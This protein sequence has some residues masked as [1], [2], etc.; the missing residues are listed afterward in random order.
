MKVKYKV[1]IIILTIINLISIFNF[2]KVIF[3]GNKNIEFCVAC[4]F[5][6]ENIHEA[7]SEGNNNDIEYLVYENKVLNNDNKLKNPILISQSFE[8]FCET[9]PDIFFD[10]CN[11]MFERL[12]FM[13]N[14]LINDCSIETICK[15]NNMC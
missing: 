8:Y 5:I 4:K 6:W 9:T 12:Y 14:D 11:Y 1:C 7:L 15:N 3:Q 13:T 2:R 10:A